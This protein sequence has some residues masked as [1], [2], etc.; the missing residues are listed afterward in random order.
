[1][2][3]K[4]QVEKQI[5]EQKENSAD[6]QNK[7]KQTPKPKEKQPLNKQSKEILFGLL[8]GFSLVVAIVCF[9]LMFVF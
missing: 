4:K 3:E 8:G 2:E 9:V 5:E 7:T 6:K 1:M